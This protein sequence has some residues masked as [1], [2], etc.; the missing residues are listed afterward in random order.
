[1]ADAGSWR[2][3]GYNTSRLGVEQ[4]H[5]DPALRLCK[6][7]EGLHRL[8]GNPYNRAHRQARWLDLAVWRRGSGV[9]PRLP[10]RLVRPRPSRGGRAKLT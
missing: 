3:I 10:T 1:M 5:D 4:D 7:G 6:S 8:W 9:R 2:A